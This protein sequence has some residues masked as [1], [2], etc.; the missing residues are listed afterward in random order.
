VLGELNDPLEYIVP[1]LQGIEI[2]ISC[3]S[4]PALKDQIPLVDAA[5]Q[6]GVKRFVPC[7]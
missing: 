7:N 5:V 3:M 2:V 1:L 6:A 4:P